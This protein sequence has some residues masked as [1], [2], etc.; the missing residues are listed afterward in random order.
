MNKTKRGLKYYSCD[1]FIERLCNFL[2]D[3]EGMSTEEIQAELEEAG[4]D[5]EKLK[6]RVRKIV[7]KPVNNTVNDGERK[8]ER[9]EKTS[10]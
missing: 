5:T 9:D 8:E 2:G 6:A 10:V 4:I 1:E 3:S 7:A